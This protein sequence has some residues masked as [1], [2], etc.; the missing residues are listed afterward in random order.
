ML[1]RVSLSCTNHFDWF[2]SVEQSETEPLFPTCISA[3][4]HAFGVHS[5]VPSN[6]HST[7]LAGEHVLLLKE[8]SAKGLATCI[9]LFSVSYHDFGVSDQ[10]WSGSFIPSGFQSSAP[11]VKQSP[12]IKKHLT[13]DALLKSS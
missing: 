2:I 6:F 11:I 10:L 7:L 13:F 8:S 12:P 5:L 3:R 9:S 4:Y 1:Q